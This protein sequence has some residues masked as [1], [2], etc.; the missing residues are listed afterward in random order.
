MEVIAVA[1][2]EHCWR[3]EIRH[4]GQTVKESKE[5]CYLLDQWMPEEWP[6]ISR[7]PWRRSAAG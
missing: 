1:E 6:R 4:H 2:R 3:W 7:R 5:R